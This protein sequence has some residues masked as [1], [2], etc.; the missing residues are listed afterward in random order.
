MTQNQTHSFIVDLV[1]CKNE[2]DPFKNEG[3]R[4]VIKDHSL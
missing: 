2:E 3:G 1:A 4:V